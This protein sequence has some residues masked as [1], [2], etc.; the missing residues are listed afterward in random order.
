VTIYKERIREVNSVLPNRKGRD[1]SPSPLVQADFLLVAFVCAA[2]VLPS[3]IEMRS[4]LR[5]SFRRLVMA[6]IQRIDAQQT[7]TKV[8]SN[9]ALLVCAYEDEAKCRRLNLDG[10]ISFASFESRVNSLPKSQEIIFY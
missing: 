1:R 9:Q 3:T 4:S 5:K 8:Q 6:D 2:P 10:S 7:H